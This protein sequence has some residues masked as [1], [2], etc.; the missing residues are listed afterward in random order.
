[1]DEIKNN[2]TDIVGN[3]KEA[4]AEARRLLPE[5]LLDPANTRDTGDG[6][7]HGQRGGHGRRG[8]GVQAAATLQ[9]EALVRRE[10]RREFLLLLADGANIMCLI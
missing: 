5:T 6:R 8:Q 2:C 3:A 7:G 4:A 9:P 10:S 1:M